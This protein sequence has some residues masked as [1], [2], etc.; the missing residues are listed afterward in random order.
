MKLIFEAS[1][2]LPLPRPLRPMLLR[3]CH[4]KDPTFVCTPRHRPLG[5]DVY[6]QPLRRVAEPKF[7]SMAGCSCRTQQPGQGVAG[8]TLAGRR[9]QQ[10]MPS[11]ARALRA[12]E[13]LRGLV[14]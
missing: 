5:F 12:F 6:K 2:G 14:G 3:V 9:L 11:P 1:R 7:G 10:E 13:S 4:L 8:P